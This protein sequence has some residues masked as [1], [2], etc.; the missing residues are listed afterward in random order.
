MIYL[1]EYCE[2]L[3]WDDE[4]LVGPSEFWDLLLNDGP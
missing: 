4:P 3:F 2:E 1:P